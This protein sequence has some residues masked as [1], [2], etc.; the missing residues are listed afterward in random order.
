MIYKIVTILFYSSISWGQDTKIFGGGFADQNQFPHQVALI[1]RQ[2]LRCGGSL[3]T[4]EWVLTAAHCVI[5]QRRMSVE[6]N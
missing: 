3:I 6:I 1:Y 2:Q 4:S 5:R